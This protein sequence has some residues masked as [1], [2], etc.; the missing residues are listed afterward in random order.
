MCSPVR[1]ICPKALVSDDAE[2]V[3]VV[4]TT[5]YAHLRDPAA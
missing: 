1:G 2:N 4:K 5:A 3:A